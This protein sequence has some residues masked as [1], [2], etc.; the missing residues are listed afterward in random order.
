MEEVTTLP[1][2]RQPTCSHSISVCCGFFGSL[3]SMRL[4]PVHPLKTMSS[5]Q[6]SITP[7]K[8]Y[9]ELFEV[10]GVHTVPG[11]CHPVRFYPGTSTPFIDLSGDDEVPDLDMQDMSRNRNL[12]LLG[13]PIVVEK[14]ERGPIRIINDFGVADEAK[15]RSIESQLNKLLPD[16]QLES[17][18]SPTT[19]LINAD[20]S[21]DKGSLGCSLTFCP[22][23]TLSPQ[24]H[25]NSTIDFESTLA[26]Q[27]IPQTVPQKLSCRER[28][29]IIVPMN[30]PPNITKAM[31]AWIAKTH[32]L[33]DPFRED[34]ECWFHPSPPSA[35]VATSGALRPC[36]KIQKW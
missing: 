11:T 23:P 35:G 26:S 24:S 32:Y 29:R 27:P 21:L 18:N 34:D 36:G 15:A 2:I 13:N 3:S 22:T 28:K 9:D 4:H 6:P 25:S 19:S 8:E 20:H 31:K 7:A 14:V 16:T 1:P 30:R 17:L 5:C 10:V 12:A 33:L